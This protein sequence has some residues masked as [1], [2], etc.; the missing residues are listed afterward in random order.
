MEKCRLRSAI[1]RWF[2]TILAISQHWNSF[3]KLTWKADCLSKVEKQLNFLT[4]TLILG[5]EKMPKRFETL[6]EIRCGDRWW[7][8]RFL[9]MRGKFEKN[10]TKLGEVSGW[11]RKSSCYILFALEYKYHINVFLNWSSCHWG[12]Q[13]FWLSDDTFSKSCR[14]GSRC[15][16]SIFDEVS[17]SKF[18]H[19]QFLPVEMNHWFKPPPSFRRPSTIIL[20]L[21]FMKTC[22]CEWCWVQFTWHWFSNF[23]L[24]DI[25][26]KQSFWVHFLI[27]VGDQKLNVIHKKIQ[28]TK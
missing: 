24:L 4:V 23:Y 21:L 18:E 2:N 1:W 19:S 20:S 3:F 15:H 25:I 16:P 22:C 11:I 27:I 13:Q 8:W 26:P 14:F 28:V 6:Y 7:W 10:Q 12:E 9:V 5:Q 17:I